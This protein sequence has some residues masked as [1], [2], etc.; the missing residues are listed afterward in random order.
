MKTILE[1]LFQTSPIPTID[2]ALLIFRVFAGIALLRGHGIEKLFNFSEELAHIPD[3]FGIGATPSLLFA[4]FAD[5]FCAILIILGAFTRLAA[6]PIFTTTLIGFLVVH[7][8]D[9][10]QLRDVPFI[11]SVVF[12]AIFLFG[13]GKYSIDAWIARK[14]NLHQLEQ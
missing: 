6:I 5:F 12:I 11:Y 14:F 2:V 10:W 4:L 1:K 8:G 3:P 13:A 9:A 7:G